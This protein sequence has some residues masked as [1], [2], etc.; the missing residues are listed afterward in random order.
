MEENHQVLMG[1]SF[2]G[3]DEM[4]L[5]LEDISVAKMSI[6]PPERGPTA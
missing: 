1:S 2:V 6:N 4:R 3:S 5:L